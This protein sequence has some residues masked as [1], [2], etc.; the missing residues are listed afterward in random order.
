MGYRAEDYSGNDLTGQVRVTGTVDASRTGLYT[1]TYEVTDSY[2]NS[3]RMTRLVFVDEVTKPTAQ[4][5]IITVIG[6]SPI[7]LHE[8]SDTPYTEQRARA[9]DHDG[10]D[11]SDRVTLEWDRTFNRKTP[12]TYYVTYSVTNDA[13]IT[14]TATREVRVLKQY[15]VVI[16]RMEYGFSGKGKQGDTVKHTNVVAA[17]EGFFDISVTSLSATA[18]TVNVINTASGKAVITDRFTVRGDKQYHIAAGTYEVQVTITTANGNKEYAINL[19]M[20]VTPDDLKEFYLAAYDLEEVPLAGWD[21]SGTPPRDPDLPRH[22]PSWY[23]PL[24]EFAFEDNEIPLA[25]FVFDNFNLPD[26]KYTDMIVIAGKKI[27]S[28]KF[29]KKPAK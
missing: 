8:H 19:K 6:S 10:T 18:I 21:G 23:T 17:S 25:A 24:D 1:I 3:A 29:R 13:G 15:D 11:I 27:Y 26:Y 7:I 28:K 9:I 4:A 12:G 20:P 22:R 14:S 16:R 5:P 2:G